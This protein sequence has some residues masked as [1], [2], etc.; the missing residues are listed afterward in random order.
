M[1][2]LYIDDEFIGEVTLVEGSIHTPGGGKK[3]ERNIE[4][5]VSPIEDPRTIVANPAYN[6]NERILVE[7]DT[8]SKAGNI[9]M[10]AFLL[11][12]G[13]PDNLSDIVIFAYETEQFYLEDKAAQ[14]EQIAKLE[15]QI[16][17]WK[18]NN[19]KA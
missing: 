5:T 17:T 8:N 13:S 14:D 10:D 11:F 15:E 4:I 19:E 9:T 18:E 16:R 2:N 1:K 12:Q 3:P 6:T 7:I